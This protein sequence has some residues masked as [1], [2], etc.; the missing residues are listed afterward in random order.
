MTADLDGTPAPP[1]RR[2]P[3]IPLKRLAG[4]LGLPLISAI[5]P[6]LVLP[7]LLGFVGTEAWAAIA[8]GQSIGTGASTLVLLGWTVVGP[9]LVAESPDRQRALYTQSLVSRLT[10]F[11]VAAPAAMV[12]AAV[13][14]PADER[15]SAALMALAMAV[16]GLSPSWFFIGTGRP[17]AIAAYD[18]VP[19]V[20]AAALA[21]LLV[22]LVPWAW[23]YPAALIAVPGVATALATA[24]YG[25]RVPFAPLRTTGQVVR[26]QWAAV[27]VSVQAALNTTLP[28]AL[29][30][31][32]APGVVAGYA[33]LERVTKFVIFVLSPVGQAFQGWVAEPS[34][35]PAHR[36]RTALLVTTGVGVVL[37]A[38][39]LLAADLLL[40]VL[41]A[42][43]IEV[44]DAAIWFSAGVIVCV[45][46]GTTLGFHHLVPL[47]MSGWL[48]VSTAVS[49]VVAAV[50][51]VLLAP[52]Y[53]VEGVALSVLLAELGVVTTQSL[54]LLLRRRRKGAPS[55]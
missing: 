24:R 40:R 54:A 3:G 16:L 2:L 47:K 12:L 30:A 11:A 46:L 55:G 7:V 14:A 43:K 51:V 44:P 4:F 21:A 25:A 52:R 39:F 50:S 18:T 31:W 45:A 15:V 37:A 22:A 38:G 41:F 33:A 17:S 26:Q 6:F 49:I 5:A 36:R 35:D 10:V 20:A 32:V 42:A 48:A 29:L 19:R 23:L 27:G 9:A 28:M 53:G 34:A 8:I 1:S 13:L